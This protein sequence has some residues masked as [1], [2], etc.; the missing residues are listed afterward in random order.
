MSIN[1]IYFYKENQKK[2]GQATLNMP[3]MRLSADLSLNCVLISVLIK[4]KF[5]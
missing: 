1:N 4:W 2:I 5:Y 3:L